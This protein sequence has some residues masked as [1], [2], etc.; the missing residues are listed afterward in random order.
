[1]NKKQLV[2]KIVANVIDFD[3]HN[4]FPPRDYAENLEDA[5]S[6]AYEEQ[7]RRTLR[8]RQYSSMPLVIMPRYTGDFLDKL[9]SPLEGKPVDKAAANPENLW[10]FSMPSE[11]LKHQEKPYP[12]VLVDEFYSISKPGEGVGEEDLKE[13]WDRS[14]DTNEAPPWSDDVVQ[15]QWEAPV[16]N[17]AARVAS[18]FLS[19]QIDC[20]CDHRIGSIIANH[21]LDI[22]PIE[23]LLDTSN[24]KTAMLLQDFDKA[25]ITTQSKGT[26]K[27]DVAGV[28]VR[29]S[30]AEP[31]VGRWTFATSSGAKPY[32]TVFQFIP[33]STV[34]DAVKLHVRVSCTCPSFLFWGAQYHA[35]MKDYLYGGVRPKFS[36]PKQRDPHGTF[37]VCKHILACMPLVSKYRLSVMPSEL[38]KKLK[39]QPKIKVIIGPE[40]KLKIPKSLEKIGDRPEILDI[41]EKWDESPRKRRNWILKLDDPD[42]VAY[43]AHRFPQTST[44]YVAERLK[45]LSKKPATK[46]EALKLLESLKNL[47]QVKEAPKT[48]EVKI[49]TPLKKFETSASLQ[50]DLQDW[51]EKDDK[52]KTKFIVNQTDPDTLAYLAYK[53][54]KDESTVSDVISKLREISKDEELQMGQDRVKA[55]HWLKDII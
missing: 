33:H 29:L 12:R 48:P 5:E 13:Y 49:P 10:D 1:M 50:N 40:E 7:P 15:R 41:V 54:Y 20:G 28:S 11:M 39:K 22:L 51:D 23:L 18:R 21:L 53:Y 31:R 47:K 2:K 19:R 17:R 55:E 14:W 8:E 6:G 36:P 32:T 4:L 37:L 44:G 42:E 52:E 9:R 24:T 43:F 34:R 27:P 30:R 35:V 45:Q 38:R 46:K 3:M 25:L 26:R 16:K